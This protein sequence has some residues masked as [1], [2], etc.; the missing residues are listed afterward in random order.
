MMRSWNATELAQ[1]L[2]ITMTGAAA[3][4][5][6]AISAI[7]LMEACDTLRQTQA[8]IERVDEQLAYFSDHC[9]RAETTARSLL[10]SLQRPIEVIVPELT[11]INTRIRE[12]NSH[13]DEIRQMG[14]R[15][16]ARRKDL[17][18][19]AKDREMAGHVHAGGAAATALLAAFTGGAAGIAFGLSSAGFAGAAGMK[20][21]EGHLCRKACARILT[22]TARVKAIESLARDLHDTLI[23]VQADSVQ[24]LD[25]VA[26]IKR[27][28]RDALEM[29]RMIQNAELATAA[30]AATADGE[31]AAAAAAAEA[32]AVATADG[33]RPR[34]AAA[35][36]A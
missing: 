30:A 10:A 13:M 11:A 16:E 27:R 23:K 26:S 7:A 36:A 1:Q 2:G 28:H 15:L 4:A 6:V 35:G 14:E 5:S 19:T 22:G 29:M 20:Y 33:I 18:R 9:T 31:A 17:A 8:N 32:A 25:A 3:A 24:L 34:R 21:Y 12:F